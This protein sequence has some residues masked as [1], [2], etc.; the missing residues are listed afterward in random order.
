MLTIHPKFGVFMIQPEYE[1]L[2][3]IHVV[4][5]HNG[6]EEPQTNVVFMNEKV[7]LT[8][9]NK[10]THPCWIYFS[11]F[12]RFLSVIQLRELQDKYAECLEI[13]HEAQEELKNF[14]NKSLPLSTTRR[15]HSLG[16]FPMVSSY[17]PTS[18][19]F[20]H[21]MSMTPQLPPI[22]LLQFC[23]VPQDSLAAEIEGTMRKELQMDDPDVEEQ[24]YYSLTIS[25]PVNDFQQQNVW[26]WC[27]QAVKIICIFLIPS[28][29]CNQ[30]EFSRQ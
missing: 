29:D 15:F 20:G 8:D 13:L 24:R 4:F 12:W 28:P 21:N 18:A 7:L 14:R 19:Y 23:L 5:L 22:P 2:V 17:S 6:L 16:L 10:T 11:L 9:E 25:E 1:L 3:F 27:K 26:S 30:N